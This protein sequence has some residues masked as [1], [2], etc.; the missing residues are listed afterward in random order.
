M[1]APDRALRRPVDH[2]FDEG[3]RVILALFLRRV[4]MAVGHHH[5]E[6]AAVDQ[7]PEHLEGR[8]IQPLLR[9]TCPR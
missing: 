5:P 6:I 2:G 7:A 9:S 1:S 4:A 8:L 3:D